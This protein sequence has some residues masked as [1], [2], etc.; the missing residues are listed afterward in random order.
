MT[1]TAPA[2]T[3]TR[4]DRWGR[5]EVVPPEGG[6]PVGY[7]RATTIAK[8]L[9][10]Q[11]NLML[12]SSRMVA[13]G[14]AQRPDLLAMVATL[15]NDD[16][17]ALNDVCERAKEAGGATVRRDLG[18]AM[19]TM[20]EQSWTIEGYEP[21]PAFAADIDAVHD[22]LATAG[23][24]V[25]GMHERIVVNDTH[26]IAG[27]FD[28]VLADAEGT[29]YISDIKTG[30]SIDAGAVGYALQLAIYATAD[31]LYTQGAAADGSADLREPMPDVSRERGLI[32]HV[33]PNSGRCEL[34]WIDLTVGIA[35]LEVAMQVR[36][37]RKAKP[38]TQVEPSPAIT[39]AMVEAMFPGVVDVTPVEHVN[40][41]WRAWI[42]G[43][44]TTI[45]DNG[46]IADL[47][48]RWPHHI[49]TLK[50][51]API[52]IE[53]GIEIAALCSTVEAMHDMAF[54]DPAPDRTPKPQRPEPRPDYV[55]PEEG[56]TISQGDVAAL[57]VTINALDDD[58][59]AWIVATVKSAHSGG[60]D[61]RMSGAGAR[62]TERRL[63][64]AS[65]LAALAPHADDE[66]LR[67]L[68]GIAIG[69]EVQPGHHLG[70]AVGSLTIDEAHRLHRLA[71]AIDDLTLTVAWGDDGSVS[72]IG[73]TQAAAAA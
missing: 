36:D 14:L 37:L 64:I 18:T 44:I 49:P 59:R 66:L 8:T 39:L 71:D 33:E 9:D 25:V 53:Q 42:T 27:T 54:G 30:S 63:A 72:I 47:A 40:D 16:K 29:L 20:L 48:A 52:T 50:T 38:L 12:W 43:R 55:A 4:R 32:I 51:G 58:A 3:E 35:A 31:A 22:A 19:H 46:H 67:T 26:R 11:S 7:T 45:A 68:L 60:R 57:N 17:R 34:H 15:P 28:L 70:R 21:P 62:R 1:I 73:D 61:I 56:A 69:D 65:A 5:Y 10:D 6:K 2:A 41:D 23:L 13:L 24:R